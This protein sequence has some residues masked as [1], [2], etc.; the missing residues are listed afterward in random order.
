MKILALAIGCLLLAGCSGGGGGNPIPPGTGPAL[1]LLFAYFGAAGSQIT[2]TAAHVNA[3]MLP[4]WGNWATDKQIIADRIVQQMQ[5]SIA[6]GVTK[7]I[8]FVDFLIW[9]PTLSYRGIADCQAFVTRLQGL[10][11]WNNVVALYVLDEPDVAGVSDAVMVQACNDLKGFGKPIAAIYGA[12][13]T[14][15]IG[16]LDW[17]GHDDY[18]I[19]ASVLQHMP[20]IASTQRWMIVPG[21]ASPYKMDPA[22][23]EA[24]AWGDKRVVAIIPFLWVDY[25]DSHGVTQQGISDNGMA[26]AYTALGQKVKA[27]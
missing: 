17:V 2:Q 19:G 16:A 9:T 5:D 15:G 25:P 21:G 13:G 23:F 7:C 24:F 18:D 1:D 8:V 26:P 12:Q 4:G 11:L 14:P 27:L 22:A 10:G 20:P 3:T 6:A